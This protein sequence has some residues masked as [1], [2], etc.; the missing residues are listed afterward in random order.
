MN[1]AKK[2]KSK[3]P[4]DAVAFLDAPLSGEPLSEMLGESFI[5]A[6]TSGEAT[7]YDQVLIEESGGPFI[8][9]E[10]DVEFAD[11]TDE[12]NPPRATREPFPKS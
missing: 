12:S 4:D 11:G 7:V 3:V 5:E 1:I 9:T 2:R 6:A 8:E 10:G